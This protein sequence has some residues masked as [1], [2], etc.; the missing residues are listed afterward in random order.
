MLFNVWGG[1]IVNRTVLF[2]IRRSQ[3]HVLN[4]LVSPFLSAS[5]AASKGVQGGLPESKAPELPEGIIVQSLSWKKN[6]HS[7]TLES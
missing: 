7:P 1:E 3:G 6:L 4:Q 2:V 5:Q